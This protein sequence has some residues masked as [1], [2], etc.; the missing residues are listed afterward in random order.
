MP[1]SPVCVLINP[2]RPFPYCIYQ[3]I[4]LDPSQNPVNPLTYRPS[5]SAFPPVPLAIP[6]Q[7]FLQRAPFASPWQI[8]RIL[9]FYKPSSAIHFNGCNSKITSPSEIKSPTGQLPARVAE[10]SQLQ[11]VQNGTCHFTRKSTPLTVFSR[12]FSSSN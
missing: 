3:P 4:A 8:T 12:Y 9:P 1:S 10:M 11:L 2:K 7:S 5:L 6:S